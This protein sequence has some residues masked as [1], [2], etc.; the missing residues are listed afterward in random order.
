[1]RALPSRTLFYSI[2]KAIKAYRKFA[3]KTLSQE[4]KN[5]TVDQVNI[6][7][8]IEEN[9]E[10]PLE[11]IAALTF[12]DDTD[13]AILEI[14]NS[15][16]EKK[17]LNQSTDTDDKTTV[18]ITNLGKSVLDTLVPFIVKNRR[19]ALDGVTLEELIHVETILKKIT[20]NCNNK[21]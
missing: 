13:S 2:E 12:T 4:I 19:N 8:F 5:I 6:L 17:Y 16:I 11:E 20:L 3:Q 18:T 14:I 9:P 1:M 21:S 15:M 7:T 10:L